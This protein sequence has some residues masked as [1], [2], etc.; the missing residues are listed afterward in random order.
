MDVKLNEFLYFFS[1]SSN[2]NSRNDFP[3][4][5][6]KDFFTWL[7]VFYNELQTLLVQSRL[8]HLF[9]YV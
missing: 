4:L 8:T 5:F 3:E 9:T 7:H 6:S 2:N 1:E